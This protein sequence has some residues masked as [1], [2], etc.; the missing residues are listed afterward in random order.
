MNRKRITL[1]ALVLLLCST[2]SYAG[3]G[4]S[5][6]SISFDSKDPHV[7]LGARHNGHDARLAITTR[8]GSVSLLLMNDVVAVQLTDHALAQLKAKDDDN[9]LEALIVSGVQIVLRKA[10]EY[11]IANLRTVEVR[12]GLLTLVN[13]QNQPVF[14]DIKINGTDVLRDF[15]PADAARFVSAFRAARGGGR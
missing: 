2:M 11:P 7:H 6:V 5:G 12:D 4:K 9:L 14:K 8:D 15:T 10:I 1:C 3:D 13:D